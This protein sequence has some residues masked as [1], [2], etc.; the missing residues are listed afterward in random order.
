MC[1]PTFK[2]QIFVNKA[3]KK[4]FN[5]FLFPF[6]DFLRKNAFDL[7]MV[8]FKSK[9]IVLIEMKCFYVE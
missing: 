2:W 6:G 5:I 7:E 3:L 8:F 1:F 4:L 9:W